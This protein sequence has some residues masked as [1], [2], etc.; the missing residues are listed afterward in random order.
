MQRFLAVLVVL[1]AAG[2]ATIDRHHRVPGWPKLE[3][4]EHYV[5][6]AEMRQRCAKY[7]GF[8]MSPVA[9]A[10]FDLV[11]RRCHVWYS[12]DARPSR[13]IQEHERMHCDGYDHVGSNG[14]QQMLNLHAARQSQSAAAGR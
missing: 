6:H 13:Y 10:E 2:C 9:C 12:A 8:G 7:V 11:N 1:L 5:P 3:I 4:V 14:M